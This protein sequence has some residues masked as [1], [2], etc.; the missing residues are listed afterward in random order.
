MSDSAG[1]SPR[2]LTYTLLGALLRRISGVALLP[3][4]EY[5]IELVVCILLLH[6]VE[7]AFVRSLWLLL[8][9]KRLIP[10]C[11]FSQ[12]QIPFILSSSCS[13]ALIAAKRSINRL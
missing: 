2:R 7:L 9:F 5:G 6:R 12:R 11:G 8:V 1:S 13:G 3:V 10:S 4:R